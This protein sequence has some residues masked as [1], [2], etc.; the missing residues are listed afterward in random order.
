M[1]RDK[2]SFTCIEREVSVELSSHGEHQQA[3]GYG[4][5]ELNIDDRFHL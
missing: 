2:F 4:D 5:L 3:P 1:G